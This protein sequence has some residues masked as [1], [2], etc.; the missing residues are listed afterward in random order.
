MADI[1][2]LLFFLQTILPLNPSIA[3][4]CMAFNHNSN[5]LVTGG[6][7]GMLRIFGKY[8]TPTHNDYNIVDVAQGECLCGWTAHQGEIYNVQFSSDETSVYSLGQDNTFCQWST[9]RSTERLAQY[10]IHSGASSPTDHWAGQLGYFPATPLGNLF[11][12]DSEDRYVLTCSPSG[13]ILYQV[14][15]TV[16][17]KSV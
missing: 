1:A 15:H 14:S 12:F 16:T 6:V 9:L 4:N 3:V 7:D 2:L 8:L 5:L 10:N 11:A 17:F 13:G